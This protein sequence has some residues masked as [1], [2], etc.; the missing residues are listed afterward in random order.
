M[1]FRNSH[2]VDGNQN[3]FLIM[4]KKMFANAQL[5]AEKLMREHLIAELATPNSPIRRE[6]NCIR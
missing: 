5:I 6:R 3:Q 1:R 2:E 4:K